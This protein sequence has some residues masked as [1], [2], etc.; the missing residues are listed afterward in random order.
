[1]GKTWFITGASR[2]FGRAFTAAAL[3][4][5]SRLTPK[6]CPRPLVP[7]KNVLRGGRAATAGRGPH[8]GDRP[9]RGLIHY[10]LLSGSRAQLPTPRLDMNADG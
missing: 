5:P 6:D 2:G 1:M 10:I 3:L 8:D 4:R 9:G 7:A